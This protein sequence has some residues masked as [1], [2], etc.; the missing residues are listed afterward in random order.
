MFAA[1]FSGLVP[2]SI[3]SRSLLLE[4]TQQHLWWVAVGSIYVAVYERKHWHLGV[5]LGNRGFGG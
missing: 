5:H 1:E 4:F 2:N 3:N